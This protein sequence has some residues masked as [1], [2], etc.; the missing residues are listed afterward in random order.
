MPPAATPLPKPIRAPT[1][2][3]GSTEPA[4]SWTA[5]A[6]GGPAAGRAVRD[7]FSTD[8]IFQ[9][10]VFSADEEFSRP[11]RLLFL[12]GLAAGLAISFSF[13]GDAMLAGQTGSPAIGALMYP[14]GFVIVV[15]GRYQL[16][17]E[18]TL[19]PVTLV[20]TRIASLPLLLRIW[21][22]VLSANVLGAALMALLLAHTRVFPPEAVE[23][24][25]EL[26]AHPLEFSFETLF[27]KGVLRHRGRHGVAEPR[28][29][30]RHRA[31]AAHPDPDL[32]RG[33]AGPGLA[34]TAARPAHRAAPHPG[35]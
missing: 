23:A 16:F 12:S 8:E 10:L 3:L 35:G 19:T 24:A 11:T 29:A 2:S 4:C 15:M 30:E 22:V 17:M 1:R 31:R 33:G 26:D 18:N 9:R 20:L 21:G 13:I 27:W 25:Y 6:S 14:L 5:S 32:P 34:R 7:T 28:G